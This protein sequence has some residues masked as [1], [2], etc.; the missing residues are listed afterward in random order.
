[1]ASVLTNR[2]IYDLFREFPSATNFFWFSISDERYIGRLVSVSGEEQI[3]YYR[4]KVDVTSRLFDYHTDQISDVVIFPEST[5]VGLPDALSPVFI[6]SE[7][8]GEWN[9]GDNPRS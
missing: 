6:G 5:T 7:W 2:K 9:A 1:M 4:T 8:V 3:I